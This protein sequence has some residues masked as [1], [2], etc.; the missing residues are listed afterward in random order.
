MLRTCQ[1][2]PLAK[3]NTSAS[4]VCH[5]PS[6][7]QTRG[8]PVLFVCVLFLGKAH[9]T[10]PIGGRERERARLLSSWQSAGGLEDIGSQTFKFSLYNNYA[11]I[12][13]LLYPFTGKVNHS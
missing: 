9:K 2:Q 3:V 1:G 4:P 12:L 10:G 6:C 8:S 5:S 11:A 7:L 13:E